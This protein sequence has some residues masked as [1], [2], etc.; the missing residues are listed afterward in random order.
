MP[1]PPVALRPKGL[2]VTQIETLRRDPYA[3]FAARILGLAPLPQVGVAP[4]SDIDPS[5]YGSAFHDALHEFC[6]SPDAG[7]AP[8]ARRARLAAI[9]RAAFADQ[10]KDP[11]FR[12]FRWRTIEK[13]LDVFLAY[14]AGQRLDAREIVTETGGKLD[15]VLA[16][17]SGF[18]LSARADR[19]D[20]H[21]DGRATLVDYKTGQPPGLNEVL[22]GFAPQLTLEAAILRKGGFGRR[23]DGAVEA[24]YLKL[25]GRDGGKVVALAFKDQPFIDVVERHYEGALRL[26][27]SF[28]SEATGYPS[29]PFP[30][31]AKAYNAYDHL[32]RVREWSLAG[33]EE[34][35][36]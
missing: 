5:A 34:D 14:D 21:R 20:F 28:R 36:P 26:L 18:A 33:D 10:L 32:A 24:T 7:G 11:T 19:I 3:I 13:S 1:K 6:R 16:D 22:V 17:G 15:L 25:G 30:K 27:S 35:A 12:V 31:Y 8:E 23:H 4:G 2:S 9:L 29:R